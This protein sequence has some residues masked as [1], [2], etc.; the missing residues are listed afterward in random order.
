MVQQLTVLAALAEDPESVPRTHMAA[1]SSS[2]SDDL[3]RFNEHCMPVVHRHA[4]G[5]ILIHI[6]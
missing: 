6:K 5:Q 1:H 2:Q 4:C 3:F